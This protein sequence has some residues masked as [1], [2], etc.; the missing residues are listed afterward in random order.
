MRSQYAGYQLATDVRLVLI[1]V[2]YKR[3]LVVE[4]SVSVVYEVCCV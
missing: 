2:A 1:M 4:C 3:M